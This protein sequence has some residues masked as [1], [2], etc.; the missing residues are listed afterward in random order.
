VP[1]L[2]ADSGIVRFALA[3]AA[4]ASVLW[5]RG[6]PAGSARE[7]ERERETERDRDRERQRETT[8]QRQRRKNENNKYTDTWVQREF[9]YTSHMELMQPM[10]ST[11]CSCI[12]SGRK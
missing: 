10:K 9:L 2:A 6:I 8:K 4:A 12:L 7:R 3:L 5:S 1:L 11:A